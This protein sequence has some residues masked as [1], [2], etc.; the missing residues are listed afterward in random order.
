MGSIFMRGD[1]FFMV[2]SFVFYVRPARPDAYAS[3]VS[4]SR[5]STGRS[6]AMVEMACL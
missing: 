2:C 3:G 4:P 1:V 5:S 6:G